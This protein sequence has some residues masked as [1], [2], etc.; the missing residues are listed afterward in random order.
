MNNDERQF[1]DFVSNIKFDDAPDPSH[2]Y[3]L[4][5]DLLAA[6]AKQPR[7]K[8]QPLQT[9]RIIM[10]SQITKLA[11]AAVIVVAVVILLTVLDKSTTPT[12]AIE[13]TI[14]TLREIESI[15]ISGYFLTADA[16]KANFQ[17]WIIPSIEDSSKSAYYRFEAGR[18][19]PGDFN[20]HDQNRHVVVVSERENSTYLYFPANTWTFYPN[21][22]IAY[23]SEGLDRSSKDPPCLGSDFFEEM[24]EQAQDWQEEY[25]EDEETGKHSVFVTCTHPSRIGANYW[26]IQFDVETK[27]PVRYR[28]WWNQN[29]GAEPA[30]S[31]DTITYNPML[32]N[33]VFEFH[34]PE[35]TKVL[36]HRELFEII[37]ANP[38]YGIDVN[39]L[40]T[41][42]AYKR[43]VSEYWE[44]VID[45]NWQKARRM[46]PLIEQQ[47]WEELQDLYMSVEP[48]QLLGIREC[49]NADNKASFPIVPCLLR[50]QNG[51]TKV[52]VLHVSIE[53]VGDEKRG[54]IVDSLGPEFVGPR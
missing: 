35:E 26:W 48:A 21:Q 4:E 9:W 16:K 8:Q 31:V 51:M 20:P 24:K 33:G 2:R 42:D 23:I 10:K 12:W 39:G 50:M 32:P 6:I 14:E 40:K 49:I 17:A 38:T 27:L 5:Q 52:G 47:K 28:L 54:V 37:N 43:I 18:F 15:H 19:E 1:E 36:D 46:R 34:I 3:K 22:K 30:A 41:E 44:A 13:Q 25:D 53:Q 11:T 29:Y 7:Q 45:Q